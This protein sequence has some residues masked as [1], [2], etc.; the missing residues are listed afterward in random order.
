MRPLFSILNKKF[1]LFA[2]FEECPSVD[3]S[4]VPYYGTA[5]DQS[6]L[7]EKS[8]SI[9]GTKYGWE[10]LGEATLNDSSHIKF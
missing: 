10:Q 7:S 4:V 9:G 3:E 2:P 1:Q 6:N 8:L 5:M